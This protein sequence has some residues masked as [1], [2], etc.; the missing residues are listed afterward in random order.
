MYSIILFHATID[1]IIVWYC[2]PCYT[3]TTIALIAVTILLL[4]PLLL[5][6]VTIAFAVVHVTNIAIAIILMNIH[7]GTFVLMLFLST[8]L[9]ECRTTNHS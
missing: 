4:L 7:A 5:T 1:K 9:G 2:C 8:P 6:S 3:T